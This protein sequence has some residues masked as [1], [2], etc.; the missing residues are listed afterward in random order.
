L[1]CED[2]RGTIGNNSCNA[3]SACSCNISPIGDNQCNTPGECAQ[4]AQCPL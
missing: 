3:A 4:P 2:N 1:A